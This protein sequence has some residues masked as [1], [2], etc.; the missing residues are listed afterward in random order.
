MG[1]YKGGSKYG[2]DNIYCH[3][4]GIFIENLQKI[5]EF[6]EI[7]TCPLKVSYSVLKTLEFTENYLQIFGRFSKKFLK[8]SL[9]F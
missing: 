7:D 1:K 2:N 9:K 6:S 4:F 5:R 3:V 8:I